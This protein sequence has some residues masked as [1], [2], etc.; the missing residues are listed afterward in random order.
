MCRKAERRRHPANEQQSCTGKASCDHDECRQ[1]RANLG[2]VGWNMTPEQVKQLDEAG[3]FAPPYPYW[4]QR[5]EFSERN[6]APV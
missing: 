1:L 3:G 2:A 6:P 5:C 4:H